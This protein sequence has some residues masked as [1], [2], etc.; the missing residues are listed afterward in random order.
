MSLTKQEKSFIRLHIGYLI[1]SQCGQ[2]A[3]GNEFPND[4]RGL[5]KYCNSECPV[6]FRLQEMGEA[7]EQGRNIDL[8]KLEPVRAPVVRKRPPGQKRKHIR[9]V[10]CRHELSRVQREDGSYGTCPKCGGEMKRTSGKRGRPPQT[11]KRKAVLV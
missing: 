6:A 10:S 2:C 5:M 4:K 3:K 1:D 9:C 11:I 7:L 8:S